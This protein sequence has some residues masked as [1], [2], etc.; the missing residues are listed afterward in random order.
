MLEKVRADFGE[1]AVSI[2]DWESDGW[3][4]RGGFGGVGMMM[5]G[6]KRTVASGVW[7]P[8]KIELYF[9]VKVFSFS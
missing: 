3:V 8:L 9:I 2:R 4:L 7:K 1:H 6:V 5:R